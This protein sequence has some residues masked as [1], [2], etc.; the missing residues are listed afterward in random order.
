[1]SE[2]SGKMVTR[3]PPY[4]YL[5]IGPP[6]CS[7]HM[8]CP[9]AHSVVE[10]SNPIAVTSRWVHSPLKMQAPYEGQV[11][12]CGKTLGC[13]KHLTL[14]VH[15]FNR[16]LWNQT[17][18]SPFPEAHIQWLSVY[19]SYLCVGVN[20]FLC[21]RGLYVRTLCCSKDDRGAL[22]ACGCSIACLLIRVIYRKVYCVSASFTLL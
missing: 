11:T 8:L 19:M 13:L 18:Q 6:V 3:W 17:I 10:L 14:H 21:V 12:L 7:H 16:F 9:P 4:P 2:G 1:M 15:S 20:P 5:L 22:V